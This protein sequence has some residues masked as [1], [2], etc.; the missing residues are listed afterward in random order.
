MIHFY[1]G[2]SR[3]ISTAT[4]QVFN[5]TPFSAN[6]PITASWLISVDK[7]VLQDFRME[8]L[9]IHPNGL[10]GERRLS[11]E[12]PEQPLLESS[13]SWGRLRVS[14]EEN[15]DVQNVSCDGTIAKERVSGLWDDVT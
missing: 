12:S 10:I 13:S 3:R 4:L 2:L 9:L 7:F 5:T 15:G 14:M 1:P 6:G 11:G 8:E